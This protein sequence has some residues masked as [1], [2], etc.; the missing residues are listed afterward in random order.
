[1]K[2]LVKWGGRGHRGHRLRGG[3]EAKVAVVLNISTI[4]R[5]RVARTPAIVS[6]IS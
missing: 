5:E 4:F 1:M 6:R 3:V 2:I